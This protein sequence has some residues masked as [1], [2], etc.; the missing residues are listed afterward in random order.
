MKSTRNNTPNILLVEGL[1]GAGKST[2]ISKIREKY[3]VLFVPEPNYQVSGIKTSI[4]EWYK[5]QHETRLKTALEYA[6]HGEH[7]VM[8]RSILSNAAFHYAKH[9]KMPDW[10][11]SSKFSLFSVAN[12]RIFFLYTDK[13]T[14]M[15]NAKYIKD[16]SVRNAI[17]NNKLFYKN[18][19]NFFRHIGFD[20]QFVNSTNQLASPTVN[21]HLHKIFGK[22]VKSDFKEVT[23]PCSS[24]VVTYGD[25]LLILY[26]KK[27]KQYTLPQ[28]HI[29]PGES[30]K[31]TIYR[32]ITEETGYTDMKVL[33]RI[34]SYSFRF[35]N[36][37]SVIK[38]DIDCFFVT[39]KNLNRVHKRLE[40]H[41]SYKNFIVHQDKGLRMLNW[42]EDRENV[43]RAYE[44]ISTKK[45]AS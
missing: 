27:H 7:V 4:T 12:L 34:R 40:K 17:K 28:G 6:S 31:K 45:P 14:F 36:D 26:S 13:Q 23:H 22:K 32:E 20:V 37:N 1:W 29:K 38:K 42:P 3:P 2:L 15:H 21:K 39:L 9:A 16:P 41:E 10:F 33:R 8:E 5:K 30:A 44:F 25:K 11:D 35:L 24:A 43:T 18:Y 19:V